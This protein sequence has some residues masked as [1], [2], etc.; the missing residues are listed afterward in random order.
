VKINLQVFSYAGIESATMQCILREIF[1]ASQNNVQIE[2]GNTS[3]DAL[4]SRARS[5]AA[6][7]FFAD[8]CDVMVMVDRDIIWEPGNV[9]YMAEAAA[10]KGALVGGLYPC[11]AYAQGVASRLAAEGVNFVQGGSAFHAAEYLATGFLAIP[12]SALVRM[13]TALGGGVTPEDAIRQCRGLGAG[14]PAFYD[15]FR[16]I[17]VPATKLATPLPPESEADF[18]Y[19][20]ED[21]AFCYRAANAGVPRL[22]WEFPRLKH[23]GRVPLS[24]ADGQRPPAKEITGG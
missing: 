19:L 12:R 4:I 7:R 1:W 18:E 2:L 10:E 24:P 8:D 16:P 9:S 22:L 14:D 3:E 15:F 6:S 11:R 13:L 17:S 20:S 21:F 5:R 23:I